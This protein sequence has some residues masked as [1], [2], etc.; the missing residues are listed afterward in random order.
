MLSGSLEILLRTFLALGVLFVLAR[1]MGRR[2]IA[3]LTL[4]DYVVGLVFGNIGASLAIDKSIG[5]LEGII[6]LVSCTIWILG[7]NIFMVNNTPTRKLMT[8][9]PVMVIYNGH[10]LEEN[11]RKNFYTMSSLFELLR[12][13]EIFDPNV[14]AI[15]II[16]SDGQLSILKKPE[17]PAGSGDKFSIHLAGRPVIIDGTL[18]EETLS[19]SKVSRDWILD[20]L[21]LRNIAIQEITVAIITPEGR[22]YVDTKTD[23]ITL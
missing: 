15:G 10:I 9:E 2:S 7:I 17:P 20:N 19:S 3:Q 6:S 23:K 1:I 5:V 14:I 22:L 4:Y 11:L 18:V 21:Q 8:A 12:E 16:E 13:Q